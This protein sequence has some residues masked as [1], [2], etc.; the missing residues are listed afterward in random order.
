MDEEVAEREGFVFCTVNQGKAHLKLN[1]VTLKKVQEQ[2]EVLTMVK[3]WVKG[4]PSK[5]KENI[6]GLS[7]DAHIYHQHLTV[8]DI[9]EGNILVRTR[10]P[11]FKKE[12]QMILV[13]NQTKLLDG[14]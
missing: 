12:L 6:R 7:H 10:S 4:D 13:P 2:D 1:L 9:D 11:I 14:S 8:M 5:S 3:K